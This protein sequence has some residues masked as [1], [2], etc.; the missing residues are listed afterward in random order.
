MV[1]DLAPHFEPFFDGFVQLAATAQVLGG[2]F[3]LLIAGVA[4]VAIFSD[5][6]GNRALKVLRTLTRMK[7]P[8]GNK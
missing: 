7:H 3:F 8:P 1:P 4:L 2:S 6:F 5:K